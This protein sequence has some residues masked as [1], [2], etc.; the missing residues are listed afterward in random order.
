MTNNA[1]KHNFTPQDYLAYE[2][3]APEKHE[4][5]AGQI[6]NMAGA[7]KNHNL[8]S[9]NLSIVVGNQLKNR[10]CQAYAHDMRVLVNK[11]GLYT[12]P[13]LVIVCGEPQFLD[14]HEDTLLNPTVIIEVLSEST[15]AYDRGDK[16][17][18]YRKLDSLQEYILV[19]QNKPG[20]E[21]FTR[22]E[23]GN[24]LYH[25]YGDSGEIIPIKSI[26]CHL[27]LRDVYDKTNVLSL[28]E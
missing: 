11:T 17:A 1:L 7:T 8:V 18:H 16:Y 14:A 25:A 28:N 19:A 13:D 2:R 22:G 24:W 27:N 10:T 3:D 26:E 20:I 15:E 4:Y 21:I 23:N 12:Y 6:Y 9:M 5:F